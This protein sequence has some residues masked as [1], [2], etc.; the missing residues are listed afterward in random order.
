MGKGGFIGRLQHSKLVNLW[1][2]RRTMQ[3]EGQF[4]QQNA[5]CSSNGSVTS[6]LL[7]ADV[8]ERMLQA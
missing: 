1:K 7:H 5:A 6:S 3:Q 8:Q 4:Q 2:S